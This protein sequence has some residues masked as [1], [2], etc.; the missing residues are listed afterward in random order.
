LLAIVSKQSHFIDPASLVVQFSRNKL[1]LYYV[2]T[3]FSG[4]FYNIAYLVASLQQ[5]FF[6][7]RLFISTTR[8]KSFAVI[9]AAKNNLS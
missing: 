2:V 3:V 9:E 7:S 8:F 6:T 1:L 5:L 4:D